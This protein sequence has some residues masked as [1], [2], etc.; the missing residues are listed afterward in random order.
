VRPQAGH[1]LVN[2][3]VMIEVHR[4]GGII[5][6]AG[7]NG[8]FANAKGDE[9]PFGNVAVETSVVLHLD[10]GGRLLGVITDAV[11]GAVVLVLAHTAGA[12]LSAIFG[13]EDASS[14]LEH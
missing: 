12:D 10:F 11:D 5:V 13:L 8:N 6:E 2:G 1:R 14:F 3:V 9:I 4:T 7:A